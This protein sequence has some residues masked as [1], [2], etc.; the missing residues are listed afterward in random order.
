VAEETVREPAHEQEIIPPQQPRKRFGETRTAMPGPSVESLKEA[1][2]GSSKPKSNAGRK[3]RAEH[4]E[5]LADQIF[6]LHQI[7]HA[8]TGLNSVILE[9]ADALKLAGP[10]HDICEKYKIA[11]GILTSP[12]MKLLSAAGLIYGPMML[13]VRL[14]MLL[15]QSDQAQPVDGM[16]GATVHDFAAAS[17]ARAA[18]RPQSAPDGMQKAE[19]PPVDLS[20]Y[21]GGVDTP[22]AE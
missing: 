18:P 13:A 3:S 14:E 17:A 19:E 8:F 1:T 5:E 10:C 22:A 2:G 9:K 21:A 6:G 16:A 20:A 12:E 7:A 15:R 11:I 4:V